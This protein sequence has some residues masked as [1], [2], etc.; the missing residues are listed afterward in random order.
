LFLGRSVCPLDE[1]GSIRFPGNFLS[2]LKTSVVIT[3]GFERNLLVLSAESF[4]QM[5]QQVTA[6]SQTDPLVRLLTR[7]LLGNAQEVAVA[8]DGKVRI[9]EHLRQLLGLEQ[10]AILVG[11]GDYLEIWPQAGWE[12][13][14]NRMQDFEANANR[15][16]GQD[17]VIRGVTQASTL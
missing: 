6:M 9:P 1:Q 8:A 3:Q 14:L 11:L 17:L 12:T 4:T 2:F 5:V 10:E 15:F 16:T 7:V 13:Q